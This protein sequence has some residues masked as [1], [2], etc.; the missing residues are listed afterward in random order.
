VKIQDLKIPTASLPQALAL[1]VCL[2]TLGCGE[3]AKPVRKD[4]DSARRQSPEPFIQSTALNALRTSSPGAPLF[5]SLS[6]EQTGVAFV[7][8]LLIDHPLNALNGSGF[9]CGGVCIGDINGDGR[10]DL[11]LI[12]GSG[13]NRLYLQSGDVQFTDATDATGVDGGEAWGAG[14]ALV[15]IDNDG[16]LDIYVCNY[17]SPNQLY[18]NDGIG[19]RFMESARQYGLDVV[20]SS[21]M[22]TFADFDNDGHLDLFLL[23]NRY[24]RP[25]GR[26]NRPPVGFQG[27]KPHILPEFQKYYGLRQVGPGNYTA[28]TCGRPDY[29]FRNNGNGTFSNVTARAGIREPGHGLSATWWDYNND[30]WLDLYVGNDFTDPDHL[31]RNNKDGTFLDVIVDTL[32]ITSWSTMGADCADLNNDGRLDFMSADMAATTHYKAKITSGDMGDRRWFLENAW[33]RQTMRNTVFLNTGT[34][35]F[36]EVGFMTGLAAT[37]WTWAVKLADFDNDSRVDVFVT[38]GSSR[39]ATDADFPVN[40]GMLI[41]RTEWD[42]WKDKPTLK[43]QNLAFR[44]EG[45]LRFSNQSTP[46]GLDHVGMSYSAACGDLDGDGDLDLV[47][48]NLDEPVAV[49]RNRGHDQHRIV[50]EL[51]GTASNRSGIGA[52]VRLHTAS[53]GPQIRQMNPATGFLSSNEPVIH[54]GLGKSAAID[55]LS[56]SWPSG[57][58]QE[59]EGL[60]SDQRYVITEP[61]DDTLAATPKGSAAPPQFTDV[62]H[63]TGLRFEHRETRFD[64]YA[65]Q[66]LLPGKHSQLGGG[67]AWGDA[68]GDGDE[69]LFVSGAAGQAG[70][71]F[72]RQ[73]NGRFTLSALATRVFEADKAF[74]DMAPLWFDSDS[75]GD[76]DL[77]VTSG[78]VEGEET[79]PKLEDRLYLNDGKGG[80]RRASAD[81]FPGARISSGVAVAGDMD[82]DG[83]LDLFIGGRVVPGR[84]PETPESR[85]LRNEGGVFSDVTDTLAPGLKRVGLVTGALWSDANGDG[86]LDLL[87][88]CEWGPVYCFINTS[89]VLQNQTRE[90]GLADRT[91]WW[92]SITGADVDQDGDID[93]F[94]G[95]VGLNTKYGEP[96][97]SKPAV[98]F[99][100]DMEGKG[101]RRIVEAKPHSLGLVPVRGRSHTASAMPF[102]AEKFPTYR[103]FASASL[104]AIYTE[105]QLGEA[106]RLEAVHFE[107]GLLM[108]DGHGRFAWRSI[109]RLAQSSPGFGV[110]ATEIDGDGRVDIQMVQNLYS[111]EPETG[112]WRGGIGVTLIGGQTGF[113]LAE[114]DQT[115][116][117]VAGDAK[118]LTVADL[119]LDGWP[120]F[121]ITQ[122]NGPLLAFQ[123][124]GNPGVKPLSI[125]LAGPIGNPTG[126]GSRVR[127]SHAD[128]TT[129]T[130][131]IYGGSGYLS[132]ST[133]TLFFGRAK[134]PITSVQTRWPDGRVTTTSLSAGQDQ[135]IIPP[136]PE[137]VSE[138]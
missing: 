123:N 35:R 119:N 84:Y 3:S 19:G 41:G 43:E 83:D 98:L 30:G 74:E 111:R 16:D 61:G 121:A 17:D 21:L 120:D 138:K 18:I 80:F 104:A 68:D 29:L 2:L 23:T 94:V 39:M 14:G 28:D 135:L 22:P 62:A 38:N 47:V 99:H 58:I 112:L 117:V 130:A 7:N 89:G 109:P 56:V 48:A 76:M 20:D 85:L 133:A 101:V 127:V 97:A 105:K 6:V 132:Q 136:S 24:Y 49:Y 81:V 42:L 57:R 125:R 63:E 66:P 53:D 59:F 65:R 46:W 78:S 12:S 67:M 25:E 114:A 103:S 9:V 107:S 69:D 52:V 40:P 54:F 137:S 37:D 27:G 116:L 115:G 93:F 91:G 31:Y 92:N 87:I 82:G 73:P 122:N 75:D 100:G 51:R 4:V 108:N 72:L 10:P 26:P 134:S 44:N 90:S 64:D 128:G 55:K 8:P 118:G 95:N 45:N 36:Q 13:R 77:L 1:G 96:S 32:P 113:H 126:I 124:R 131:E 5:E 50:I 129:Q 102:V 15:D 106:L 34:D 79:D 110:V 88:T 86:A 71:L 11:Y 70:R 33:P 60:V